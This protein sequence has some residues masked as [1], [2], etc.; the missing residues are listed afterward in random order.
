MVGKAACVGLAVISG[1]LMAVSSRIQGNLVVYVENP[2]LASV[3]ANVGA[4]VT[5]GIA[6]AASPAARRALGR[7]LKA[8][9]T[10]GSSL[11]WWQG[12]G[13]VVGT[14]FI[15]TQSLAVDALGVAI[16]TVASVAGN[17]IGSLVVDHYGVAPGGARPISLPRVAGALLAMAAAGLGL[18]GLEGTSGLWLAALPLVVGIGKAWQQAVSGRMQYTGSHLPDGTVAGGGVI[19]TTFFN[20]AAGGILLHAMFW[21][22]WTVRGPSYGSFPTNPLWYTAGVLAVGTIAI[23]AA[24]VH[25]IGALLLILSSIAGQMLAALVVDALTGDT[26]TTATLTAVALTVFAVVLSI[27]AGRRKPQTA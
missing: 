19:A 20:F 21:T 6:L 8:L 1:V 11:A 9:R 24:V 10:P 4:M 17:S 5:I 2:L 15:L 22:S 3:F 25:R 23:S 7:V 18:T 12:L 14:A 27:L 16:F 13:P 26:P